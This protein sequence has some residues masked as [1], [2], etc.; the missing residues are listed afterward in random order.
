MSRIYEGVAKSEHGLIQ[1]RVTA[2]TDKMGVD[3]LHMTA[4]TRK[5]FLLHAWYVG[6]LERVK[7]EGQW[8]T[9][10]VSDKRRVVFN[11]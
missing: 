7:E 9:Q 4:G 6:R 8:R 1:V 2:A 11:G 5:A 3:A 10:R